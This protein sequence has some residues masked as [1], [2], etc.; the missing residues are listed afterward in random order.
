MKADVSERDTSVS[1]AEAP[2]DSAADGPDGATTDGT[3]ADSTV[4]LEKTETAKSPAVTEKKGRFRRLRAAVA[5]R[6]RRGRVVAGVLSV[7]VVAA[8]AVVLS[9]YLALTRPDRAIDSSERSAATAA[10]GQGAV[11][12]LAYEPAKL[13]QDFDS[14]KQRLTGPFRD[15][16]TT[17]TTEV[18]APAVKAKQ[19]TSAVTV[20]GSSLTS[21]DD[22]QATALVFVNQT[23]TSTDSK[24]PRLTSSSIKVGMQK[25]DGA[26]KISSFDPV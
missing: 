10:A 12:I 15:Y 26:W 18:V 23:V 16:Y 7:L 11:A 6:T 8:V 22:S 5:P 13:Q 19:I 2:E 21:I 25:V 17:F 14:A 3:A 20:V 9:L 1:D 4:T 24:D